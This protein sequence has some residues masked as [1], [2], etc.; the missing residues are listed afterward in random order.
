MSTKHHQNTMELAARVIAS[1]HPSTW[2]EWVVLLLERLHNAA[3]TE[4]S[5]RD[6][7]IDLQRDIDVRLDT[8][9]W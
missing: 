8:G 9:S 6:M 5:Y 4:N 7:L 1:E 3:P 2:R